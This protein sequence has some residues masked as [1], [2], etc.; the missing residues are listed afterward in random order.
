MYW[1]FLS[2]AINYTFF[3][4]FKKQNGRRNPPTSIF[5]KT[6]SI[7]IDILIYK[8]IFDKKSALN[9]YGLIFLIFVETYNKKYFEIIALLTL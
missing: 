2:H 4:S 7:K 3:S 5:A 1:A 9:I 6:I 8:N